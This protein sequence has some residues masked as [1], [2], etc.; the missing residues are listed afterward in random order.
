M[1]LGIE[2]VNCGLTTN[3]DALKLRVQQ[4]RTPLFD[5][6]KPPFGSRTPLPPLATHA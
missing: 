1:Q 3:V 5:S 4:V 2:F 6:R